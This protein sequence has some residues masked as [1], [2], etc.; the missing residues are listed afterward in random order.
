MFYRFA[1]YGFLK[2]LKFFDPFM[3]LFF[4]EV[5]LSF[6]QIGVLYGIRDLATTILEVPT[7]VLADA[8]GRR[9]GMLFSFSAYIISFVLFFAIPGFWP[10]AFAML[11]FAL[12][13]AFRTGTHKALILEHLKLRGMTDL[14]IAYYGRT[15]AASQLG[16][17]WNALIAAALVF[18]SGS[19]RYIFIASTVPYVLDFIN[20]LGYPKELDGELAQ[21]NGAAAWRQMRE[22]LRDF[23]A[24]F[25]HLN[26][27]KA[28][29]NSAAFNG[30]FKATKDYLQ[31][32]L[33][34]FALSLPIFVSLADTRRSAVVVG[35]VYT[36]LYLLT[37]YASRSASD[38]VGRLGNLGRALDVTFLAAACFLFIAGLGAWWGWP[39]LSIVLF[40]GLYLLMNARRPMSVSYVSDQIAHRVMASGLSAESQ[41]T[42][43]IMAAL[44]PILGALAD[45]FGVG[46]ALAIAGVLTGLTAALVRVGSSRA[47]E[48]SSPGALHPAKR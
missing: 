2:N 47:A 45:S 13:E 44:A 15:R 36:I 25:T 23:V 20:L 42:T 16:S 26:S 43:I 4:R 14:K 17:A 35:L 18:Y 32:L 29:L 27:L 31:P 28:I 12:G 48:R 3:I 38:V 40:V 6:L 7:G 41:L 8:F 10:Y 37:S 9:R 21:L 33:K 11:L 34:S 24:I 5:G 30:Y 39:A 1:L 19:Y 46:I 22:T